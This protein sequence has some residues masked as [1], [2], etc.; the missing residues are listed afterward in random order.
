MKWEESQGKTSVE[1]E[2]MLKPQ[3]N[4]YSNALCEAFAHRDQY[5]RSIPSLLPSSS[6]D[7]H[8]LFIIITKTL[9]FFL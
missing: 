4:N 1:G 2:R 6:F 7:E 3:P 5:L 8:F 9:N